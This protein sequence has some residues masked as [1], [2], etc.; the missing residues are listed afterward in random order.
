MVRLVQLRKDKS[1]RIGVVQEPNVRLLSRFTS[2][3]ALAQA[4][5]LAGTRVDQLL[6]LHRTGEV[7]DYDSIYQGRSEWHLALP[8]DHPDD[9]ARCLVSGT[10]LTH[11][12]SAKDRN[13]MHEAKE[14][15]LTDSM[16]MFR[17]GVED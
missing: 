10:G 12:G 1:R 14:S 11:L 7:L 15:E 2:I 3:Y 9:P 16:K 6:E 4:A 8:I 5:I 17:W 13:A